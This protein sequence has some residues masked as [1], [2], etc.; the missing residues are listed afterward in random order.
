MVSADK[1]KLAW[2]DAAMWQ[3]VGLKADSTL[4]KLGSLPAPSVKPQHE[5]HN[6]ACWHVMSKKCC[7]PAIRQG[8]QEHGL[9]IS[10]V[11]AAAAR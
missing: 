4:Q 9:I 2:S 8:M 5:R 7:D 11:H 6:H 1:A 3:T 10:T